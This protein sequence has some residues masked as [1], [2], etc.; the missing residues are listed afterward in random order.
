MKCVVIGKGWDRSLRIFLGDRSPLLHTMKRGIGY[1]VLLEESGGGS[2]RWSRRGGIKCCSFHSGEG[3]GDGDPC[4]RS[5]RKRKQ[6]AVL[7]GLP[8]DSVNI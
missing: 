5:R 3:D 2:C 4:R 7:E 1:A 8:I 6:S